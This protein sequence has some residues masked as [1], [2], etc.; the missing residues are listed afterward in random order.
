M[1]EIIFMGFGEKDVTIDL[2]GKTPQEIIDG[3]F[4]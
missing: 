3:I 4:K 1:A 2:T